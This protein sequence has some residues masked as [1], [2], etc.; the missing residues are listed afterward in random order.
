MNAIIKVSGVEAQSLA[1]IRDYLAGDQ[2]PKRNKGTERAI[3]LK[4]AKLEENKTTYLVTF[5]LLLVDVRE[6]P[7]MRIK[8]GELVGLFKALDLRLLPEFDLYGDAERDL[9]E[10]SRRLLNVPAP[11]TVKSKETGMII[12]QKGQRITISRLRE[13]VSTPLGGLA[14]TNSKKKK[15]VLH[16]LLLWRDA[17]GATECEYDRFRLKE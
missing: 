4:D 8:L 15:H 14:W 10:F 9:D 5:E 16:N 6:A 3:T 7:R 11:F 17:G 13:I 2:N 1:T 12:L